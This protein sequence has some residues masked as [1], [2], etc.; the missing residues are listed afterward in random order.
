MKRKMNHQLKIYGA[1]ILLF[2]GI[3]CIAAFVFGES[4][5]KVNLAQAFHAPNSK[6]WF[7]T[8]AL[9]RSVFERTL[10]G[11]I[12]TVIP[13]LFIL[14]IVVTVGSFIG[15][16]SGLIGGK[17]DRTIFL[18]ITAF[19]AF[20]A[21]IFV[22]ML[23][24]ILGVGLQQTVIAI[25]MTNWAKYAYLTRIL[26]LQLKEE[27]YIQSATMFGNEYLQTIRNYY[28][29][30]LFPQILTTAI[31]DVSNT[32]ME[33]AG[34]SFIGLGA[35]VPSPEWGA[36]INDGRAYIQEAPW[37][38]VFPCLMIILTVLLF[39]RFGE[40]LKQKLN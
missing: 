6:E 32:I 19:Q 1:I 15:I 3:L 21:I 39:T 18:I 28:L 23:V 38:V 33:I 9:G 14:F 37:I 30:S 12:Q 27:P 31:F 4:V 5:T 2:I 8:D 24:G 7:G 16:S 35:Q 25:C 13:S 17:F 40:L 29:P 34:L 11:G 26:T 10:S 36:M 22:I 20:P